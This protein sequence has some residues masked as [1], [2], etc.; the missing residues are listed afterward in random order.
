MDFER[1]Y[2]E[3]YSKLNSQQKLAVDSI[4]GPVMV[5][6]GPG[7]GKT[8]LLSM[9]VANILR[10]TDMNPENILC[11]TFTDAAS[12]NMTERMSNLFGLAAYDV[13][14]HTFHSFTSYAMNRFGEYFGS[15][16]NFAV[17]SDIEKLEILNDILR[18]L[19]HDNPLSGTNN[20]GATALHLG[21]VK[22]AISSVKR[23]GAY[24]AE[25]LRAIAQEN[26]AF[27]DFAEPIFAEIFKDRIAIKSLPL[28]KSGY[29][30][31]SRYEDAGSTLAQ[32][33]RDDFADAINS[34]IESNK[35]NPIT[36]FK[37]RHGIDFNKKTGKIRDR[38]R[39]E[40]ILAL[41]DVYEKYNEELAKKQ[42]FDFDD[43][44]VNFVEQ[45]ETN[46]DFRA[47]LQEQFQYILVDEF[48]DTNDAQMRILY[49]IA[50][51]PQSNIMTVG[52]DDQAIYSFQGA[53]LNNLRDF[54]EHYPATKAIQL[55]QNYRSEEEVLELA[56]EVISGSGLRLKQSFFE[57]LN[58]LIAKKEKQDGT[59]VEFIR[60]SSKEAEMA[61]VAE[62]IAREIEENPER[63]IAVISRKHDALINIVPYLHQ[64][65]ITNLEYEKNEDVL[66]NE[67]VKS[68]LTLTRA[69][70]FLSENKHNKTNELIPEIISHPAW[71][72][73]SKDIW[74]ISLNASKN[75]RYWL[76]EMLEYDGKIQE[77]A[78][79]LIEMAKESRHNSLEQMLDKLFEKSYKEYY[80]SSKNLEDNPSTY[81]DFLNN[82]VVLREVAR[83]IK[84]NP[85][86]KTFIET[87]NLY[88]RYNQ[89]IQS[90]RK[91]GDKA[92]V[93]L[94]TAHGAKGLEFDSVYIIDAQKDAWLGKDK[95][96]FFPSNLKVELP[97]TNDE[98]LRVIF[99]AIT[100]AKHRLFISSARKTKKDGSDLTILPVLGNIKKRELEPS[101]I[102]PLEQ[103]EIEWFGKISDITQ[104]KR[105]I[106]APKL[107]NYKLNATAV[108]SFINLEYAGPQKFLQ[109]NLLRFPSAKSAN[110]DYGTAIHETFNWAHN[111]FL[112]NNKK[113]D[114]EA[115]EQFFTNEIDKLNMQTEDRQYFLK[116]GLD[117]LPEY[118]E[119]FPFDKKQS[120]EAIFNAQIG[121]MRL[122]GKLDLVE[123]DEKNKT[124]TIWDHKTGSAFE[125]FNSNGKMKSHTYWQQ[126]MF[127]KI[128]VE[129]SNDRPGYRVEKAFINFVDSDENETHILEINYADDEIERFTKL[130]KVIWDKIQ[131]LDFP[132]TDDFPKNLK[133]SLAFE[134]FLIGKEDE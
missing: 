89:K 13:A 38:K 130:L 4:E 55:F 9:R 40:N 29:E 111:F 105:E 75:K 1:K 35:T 107:E 101:T 56:D 32:K 123:I 118:I 67:V 102:T 28:Y 25:K 81:I 83:E 99:V 15:H 16:S 44:I 72:I 6:A 129:N 54:K 63:E 104:S 49:A 61:W 46:S 77:I 42:L 113:P 12:K 126:L 20:D 124:V 3:E 127:Y 51:D 50:D 106:L 70:T 11:L 14:V 62:N 21:Q 26:L 125:K 22:G 94:M 19:P 37:G 73:P 52:D 17:A 122:T 97:G 110:A 36:D 59:K 71:E 45:V 66:E 2:Q 119:N 91:F 82:L 120:S 27:I 98:N 24:T 78:N 87:L 103:A 109:N 88:A 57:D 33:I 30:K 92:N 76:E 68:L 85:D 100:R 65:K 69:V 18:N 117:K 34:A 7:T 39:T 58:K 95:N 8:Q 86:L 47:D 84:Q 108:N 131:N 48:Q 128:L 114:R 96:K 23:R 31:L 132:N 93:H 60:T 43:M 5:L 90:G 133:G 64:A 53:N 115:I 74:Q 112:K 134:D 41:A 121:E 116:K 80:F 10:K 79:W